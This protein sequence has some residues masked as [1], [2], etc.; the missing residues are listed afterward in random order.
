MDDLQ[1]PG[2]QLRDD[3]AEAVARVFPEDVR[4]R[5]LGALATVDGDRCQ[6]AVLVLGTDGGADIARLEHFA[7]VAAIDFRDVLY[8]AE[9]SPE[10][11]DYRAA[12]VRLGLSRPY[13]V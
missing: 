11:L 5:A 10:R 7:G 6:V 8:W 2:P 3:V 9:Y 4:H 13:P 12:L 1:P